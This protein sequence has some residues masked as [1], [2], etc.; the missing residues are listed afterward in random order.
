MIT[1]RRKARKEGGFTMKIMKD[2]KMLT[3]SREERKEDE[4]G[5]P[6]RR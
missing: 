5:L 2:M 3:Q 6:Q 1:Q 4:E